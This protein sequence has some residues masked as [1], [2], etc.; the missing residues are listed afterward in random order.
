MQGYLI[1]KN[2]TEY[3]LPELLS[4]DICHG[5]GEPC[6]Y[7]E[8]TVLYDTE[9]LTELYNAVRFRAKN[10][11]DTVFYGVV[12]EYI[13]NID[14]S[15]SAVSINGRSLAALLMDNELPKC[16]HYSLSRDTLLSNYVTP[17]GV[18]DTAPCTLPALLL[19]PVKEGDSA[20]S[21]LKRYCLKAAHTMPR[22]T[23]AGKLLMADTA[24]LT[25]TLNADT[26]ASA[27]KCR[28]ERY[29]V[30]SEI[31]VRN[32][33]NN[34]SY[35]VT[36]DALI[37]RGGR[38][39]RYIYTDTFEN[40]VSEMSQINNHQSG[41]YQIEKSKLGKHCIEVTVPQQFF[42]FPGDT[43]NFSSTALGMSGSYKVSSTHCWA[44]SYGAGTVI[45]LEV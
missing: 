1:D 35:T 21:V 25:L 6:D 7:F 34:A 2:G 44:D 42:C 16:T 19:F 32:R 4:W 29:G 28:D 39:R 8:V 9:M 10:G 14:E 12:D 15:G 38:C 36:N 33:V 26:Q 31:T 20:W 30:I 13:I 43:V 18:T 17:F 41:E 5:L 24:G 11:N 45:R 27:V 37:A 40:A 3:E 22:F 23:R